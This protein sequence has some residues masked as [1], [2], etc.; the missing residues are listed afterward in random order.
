MMFKL[1]TRYE[2]GTGTPVNHAQRDHWL[3]KSA[4]KYNKDAQKRCAELG[5]DWKGGGTTPAPQG[6]FF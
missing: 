1:A 5:L 3:I 4:K 6:M 2:N